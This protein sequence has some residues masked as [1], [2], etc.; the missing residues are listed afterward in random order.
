MYSMN[1][2]RSTFSSTVAVYCPSHYEL[3][4]ERLYNNELLLLIHMKDI[5]VY[6]HH[7]EGLLNDIVEGK[8]TYD[9][10]VSKDLESE[11][12]EESKQDILAKTSDD[13]F[14]KELPHTFILLD[15]AI[16]ILTQ[17]KYRKLQQMLFRNRQSRFTI[18]IF[19]QTLPVCHHKS[20][21]I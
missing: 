11:L 3:P 9:Q 4:A 7:G 18:C 5:Q 17:K 14:Y 6:Y 2:L 1:S 13:D 10:V 21:V 12:T 16:N 8:T 15:D 19:I 20:G